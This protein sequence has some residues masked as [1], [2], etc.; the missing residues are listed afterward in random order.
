MNI[1]KIPSLLSYL[2]GEHQNM[3]PKQYRESEGLQ[4]IAEE[5]K[6]LGSLTPEMKKLRMVRDM[7]IDD[8]SL[9]QDEWERAF[10]EDLTRAPAHIRNIIN[11]EEE[12]YERAV[13]L[14]NQ[15]F[16]HEV[17]C[18]HGLSVGDDVFVRKGELLTI[19][20]KSPSLQFQAKPLH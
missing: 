9:R 12:A 3:D 15:F 2:W 16:V 8:K 10:D 4:M 5:E 7:L 6:I 14:I 20:T 1:L 18:V 19:N 17:I 11:A 13:D